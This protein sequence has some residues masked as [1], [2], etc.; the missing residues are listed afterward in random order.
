MVSL[1]EE[2]DKELTSFARVFSKQFMID[3]KDYL[4]A[5]APNRRS[6]YEE[7]KGA[8]R[9]DRPEVNIECLYK[10]INFDGIENVRRKMY[11]PIKKE[12]VCPDGYGLYL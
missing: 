4:A 1:Y 9:S 2:R 8:W 3:A 5:A 7:G 10:N 6:Q 12:R 11:H